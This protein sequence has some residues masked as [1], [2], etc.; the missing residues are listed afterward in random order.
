MTN[1]VTIGTKP[2]PFAERL[3]VRRHQYKLTRE[4]LRDLVNEKTRYPISVSTI[5]DMENPLLPYRLPRRWQRKAGGHSSAIEAVAEALDVP[6]G[7]FLAGFDTA[8]LQ[9][10]CFWQ[11]IESGKMQLQHTAEGSEALAASFSTFLS[12]LPDSE[13]ALLKLPLDSYLNERAFAVIFRLEKVF[14]RLEML[15]VNDP[16]LIF[17]D[18]DD[19]QNWM[20]NMSLQGEDAERFKE[21]FTAYR[22]HFRHLALTSRKRYKIVLNT[23]TFRRWLERKKR[24]AAIEQLT[25]MQRFNEIDTFALTLLESGSSIEEAEVISKHME[26][27]PSYTDTLAAQIVQTPPNEHPTEYSVTPLPTRMKMIKRQRERID[28]A[29]KQAV[30]QSLREAPQSYSGLQGYRKATHHRLEMLKRGIEGR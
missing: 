30:Q 27:P 24:G 5:R 4:G 23:Y 25:A 1:R 13:A 6:V 7:Y 20:R 10:S 21:E 16:P 3:K 2:R 14:N 18:D 28:Q 19:V 12:Q 26:V 22:N 15:L 17:W 29:W 9:R 11:L 8:A